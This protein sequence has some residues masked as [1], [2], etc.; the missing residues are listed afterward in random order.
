APVRVLAD[1]VFEALGLADIE[2]LVVAAEHA[3]DARA[4]GQTLPRLADRLYALGRPGEFFLA[5][6]AFKRGQDGFV[7]AGHRPTVYPIRDAEALRSQPPWRRRRC[8]F[9]SPPG[10]APGVSGA[11]EGWHDCGAGLGPRA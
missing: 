3:V 8:R 6:Q 1:P 10:S 7:G 5:G 4:G 9:M 2:H 11:T